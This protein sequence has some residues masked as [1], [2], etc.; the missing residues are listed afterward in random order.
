[1]GLKKSLTHSCLHYTI[2]PSAVQSH[3]PT[4]AP[5][6]YR[7]IMAQ[8]FNVFVTSDIG[9]GQVQTSSI[10]IPSVTC[11]VEV[12]LREVGRRKNVWDGEVR[13][14]YNDRKLQRGKT[15]QDY[16]INENCSL[17]YIHQEMTFGTS[18]TINLFMLTLVR[19]KPYKISISRTATMKDLKSEM[20]KCSGC[21]VD[22]LRL[23]YACQILDDGKTVT[24]YGLEDGFT[25][26][27]VIKLR[28]S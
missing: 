25:I 24:D 18:P 15:L 16:D 14:I 22:M 20:C 2:C 3:P 12:L 5:Q 13:L 8:P 27:M 28:G 17:A 26:H 19:V 7:S 23:L 6:S 10:M 11:P 9:T 1:M 21:P 4:S